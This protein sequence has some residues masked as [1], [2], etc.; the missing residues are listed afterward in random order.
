M[1]SI[2]MD[3]CVGAGASGE[4]HLVKYIIYK[5]RL[6]PR[7]APSQSHNTGQILMLHHSVK[8]VGFTLSLISY[9]D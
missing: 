1:Y 2:S 4:I 9:G 3:V 7:A 6:K 8:F 5:D